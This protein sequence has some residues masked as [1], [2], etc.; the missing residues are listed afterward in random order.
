[1]EFLKRVLPKFEADQID[2][3]ALKT[4]TDG[5][6]ACLNRA[7]P[8]ILSGEQVRHLCQVAMRLLD[9]SFR[10]REEGLKERKAAAQEDEDPDMGEDEG[11]EQ[12]LRVSLC[13]IAGSI[14]KHHPDAFVAEGLASYLALVQKLAQPSASV[15]DRKLALFVACDFLDHLGSRI[16]AQW[17][18]FLPQM[19]EDVLHPDAEL[20]QPACYGLSLAAKD[21]AFAPLAAEAAGKLAEV[22]TQSRKREKK[23]S[24][25]VTQACADNALSALA[26][27]LLSHQAALLAGGGAGAEA[28][29]WS[30]WVQGLP[31]QEDEEEGVRNHAIL[32]RLVQQERPE[33]VGD[34]GQNVSKLL[35]I[36]VDLYKT[37]M[38][39]E[40]TSKGIGQLTMRIGSARL[41][42]YA[43]QYTAK[44]RKKLLRITEE[45][46]KGTLP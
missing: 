19:L 9:E 8:G 24:E 25:R 21:Q 35:A 43:A 4:R 22:V 1:M 13:E 45:A 17:P 44:Q 16:I 30:V 38:V 41:E 37:D 23:K 26:Q 10:R 31:C 12:A 40:E 27:L 3:S 14:M 15:D 5:V 7:G 2:T 33:I 34:G 28:H 6:S 46:Q 20:R 32:L 18:Q 42:Q 29:Y 11:E 39:D 36:L